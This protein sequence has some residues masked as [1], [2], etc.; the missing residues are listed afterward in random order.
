MTVKNTQ[1]R[2][3]I[4]VGKASKV[5]GLHW[6]SPLENKQHEK[7]LNRPFLEIKVINWLRMYENAPILLVRLYVLRH[8]PHGET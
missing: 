6:E 2:L 7:L 3:Y 8:P 5:S 4:E 1:V